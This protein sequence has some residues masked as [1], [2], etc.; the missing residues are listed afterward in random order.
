MDQPPQEQPPCPSEPADGGAALPIHEAALVF[1]EMAAEEFDQL[2]ADIQAHGL[3]EPIITYEGHVLDGRHRDRA[4]RELGIE[5]DR[6]EWDGQGS[7]LDYVISRNVMRRHLDASQRGMVAAKLLPLY[8]AEADA[9]RRAGRAPDH[10]ANSPT[11]RA[12][13]LVAAKMGVSPRTVEEA[14]VVNEHGISELVKAVEAGEVSASAGAEVAKL[15]AQEQQQALA[16]GRKGVANTAKEARG[17]RKS[18][19]AAKT[20]TKATTEP[21]PQEGS[22]PANWAAF[23]G[24]VKE[25]AGCV[26]QLQVL[27]RAKRADRRPEEVPA[28]AGRIH[29]LA[30]ALCADAGGVAEAG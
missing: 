12:R 4:C 18:K 27:A 19:K 16:G 22:K 9:R 24:H 25:L 26:K 14:S 29:A 7:V 28:F 3:R 6:R 5:P 30:D 8:E 10:R 20:G 13:D 1:P 23:K 15:P 17:K 21:A 2:K 11:G